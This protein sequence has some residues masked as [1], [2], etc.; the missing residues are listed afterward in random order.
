MAVQVSGKFDSSSW[1]PPSFLYDSIRSSTGLELRM[2]LI[3]FRVVTKSRMSISM[4]LNVVRM[5]CLV[6]LTRASALPFLH[7]ELAGVNVH[8]TPVFLLS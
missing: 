3:S 1:A 6:H 8:L 2:L 7:C 4:C 5:L